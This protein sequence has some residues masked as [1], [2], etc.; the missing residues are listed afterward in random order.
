[1]RNNAYVM[2]RK[3][4]AIEMLLATMLVHY[5]CENWCSW[6]DHPGPQGDASIS[7]DPNESMKMLQNFTSRFLDLGIRSGHCIHPNLQPPI[8]THIG[9]TPHQVPRLDHFFLWKKKHYSHENSNEESECLS[10]QALPFLLRKG[11]GAE[12]IA[13]C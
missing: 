11:G 3:L 8:H 10:I 9:M 6:T 5:A 1:M 13:R 2:K 12:T 4:C 7:M